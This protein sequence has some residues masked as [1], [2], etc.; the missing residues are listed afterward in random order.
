MRYDPDDISKDTQGV[1]IY[2]NDNPNKLDTKHCR[3]TMKE[4]GYEEHLH[5]GHT[6]PDVTVIQV[7]YNV[8]LLQTNTNLG[9]ITRI[10]KINTWLLEPLFI[11][12]FDI[13]I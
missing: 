8:D 9:R 11:Q 1:R 4:S 2:C 6:L 12:I 5:F 13:N 3:D 7:S 10:M